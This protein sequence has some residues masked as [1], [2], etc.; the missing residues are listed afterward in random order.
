M[1]Y[2]E[3]SIP[4][5]AKCSH[6]GEKMRKARCVSRTQSKMSNGSAAQFGP[7]VARVHPILVAGRK[8]IYR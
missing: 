3:N 8:E 4:V 2:H 5:S 1:I 7:L 6:C